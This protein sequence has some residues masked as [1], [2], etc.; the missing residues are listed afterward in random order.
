MAKL[1][2]NAGEHARENCPVWAEIDAS[3]LGDRKL[4]LKDDAGNI[5]PAQAAAG[6]TFDNPDL[7]RAVALWPT[8]Q[9]SPSTANQVRFSIVAPAIGNTMQ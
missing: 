3:L 1:V 2:V 8:I 9:G 7:F 6:G 4:V 5:V